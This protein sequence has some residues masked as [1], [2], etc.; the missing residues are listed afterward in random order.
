MRHYTRIL[1]VML[2]GRVI[3]SFSQAGIEFRLASPPEQVAIAP[4]VCYI[5]PYKI[6]WSTMPVQ[7]LIGIIAA[8]RTVIIPAAIVAV[9]GGENG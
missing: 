4:E 6:R 7:E 9:S 1:P 3:H 8:F 5:I 2:L